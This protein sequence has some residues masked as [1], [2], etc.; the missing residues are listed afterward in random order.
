MVQW[1]KNPTAV[2]RVAAEVQVQ[3]WE[4]PYAAGV[5]IKL[6]IYKYIYVCSDHFHDSCYGPKVALNPLL[7]SQ[8]CLRYLL[9]IF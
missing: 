3:S 4:L 7:H 1:A 8:T 6:K 2:G 9:L 5:A